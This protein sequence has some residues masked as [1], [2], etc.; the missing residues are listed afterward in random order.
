MPHDNNGIFIVFD[1]I[2]GA[3]KTTQV[4]LLASA[5]R[6]AGFKVTTSKEPTDGQ[7][8]QKIR[9]S[10]TSGRM[11]LEE[12]LD[13]FI[14]DRQEHISTLI[15]PALDNNEIV[16]L[17]RYYYST[18]CYQGAS[19]ADRNSLRDQVLAMAVK[20]DVTFIMDVNPHISQERI[21][22]RDGAPNEFENVT[23]LTKVRENYDW[24]C[25]TDKSLYELDS[26]H[27]IETL[28]KSIVEILVDGK[29]KEKRCFKSYDCDDELNCSYALTNSCEWSKA[30]KI[31]L[32]S[33]PK[34]KKYTALKK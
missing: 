14:K 23:F 10:A 6:S 21:E 34:P 32:S 27:S 29:L 17:D 13:A 22:V 30:K 1:G 28:H 2:D 19:G 11:P 7:W 16:I 9:E 15:Q 18:I 24:L 25:Q 3:G 4:E 8:G 31:L 5:L 33:I 20:P 12:E 26:H